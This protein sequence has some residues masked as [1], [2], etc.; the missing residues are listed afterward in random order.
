MQY[1]LKFKHPLKVNE[2]DIKR[3][4]K[5]TEYLDSM[6]SSSKEDLKAFHK[7]LMKKNFLL[8][9]T[10]G[11]TKEHCL[12]MCKEHDKTYHNKGKHPLTEDQMKQKDNNAKLQKDNSIGKFN[13]HD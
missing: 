6:P 4:F 5:D 7:S 10:K 12:N 8:F 3:V 9:E 11:L 2:R 1:Y 13:T